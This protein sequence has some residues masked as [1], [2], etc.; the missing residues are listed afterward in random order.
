[1]HVELLSGDRSTVVA[2]TARELGLT[3]ATGELKPQDKIQRLEELKSQGRK[4]LMVGD[5]LNDA[6][7]LAAAHV[8]MSP[9]SAADISQTAADFV[10]QTQYL[11]AVI[12]AYQVSHSSRRLVLQNFSL[13]AAYNVIAIPVAAIGLLTPLIAAI[14]MS[15]SSLVVTGNA[16]RLNLMRLFSSTAEQEIAQPPTAV[17]PSKAPL[18]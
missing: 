7:A 2:D 18:P 11:S 17:A 15:G 16:L 8:S 3:H 14:A 6:P 4:I 10:F 12:K 13:A 1:M 9:S 5:G